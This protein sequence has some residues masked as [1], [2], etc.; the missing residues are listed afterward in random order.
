[1]R[2]ISDIAGIADPEALVNP[3]CT[4]PPL[5]VKVAGVTALPEIESFVLAVN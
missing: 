5:K 1:V 4:V 3:H 2:G